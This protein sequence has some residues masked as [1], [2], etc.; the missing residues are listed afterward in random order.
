LVLYPQTLNKKCPTCETHPL[1]NFWTQ[2]D[3]KTWLESPKAC[4]GN[5][6]KYAFLKDE[7]GK[8]LPSETVKV[9]HKAV[10]AGWT[11]LVNCSIAL[12]TWGKASASACQTFHTILEHEFLIFKLAENGWKLEYLCT[13]TYSAWCKHHLNEN[14]QWKMAV[15][16]EDDSDEDS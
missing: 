1:V 7:N 11:E 9:I 4:L 6:G 5:Q 10:H 13:K 8:A 2:K 14:G 15:K 12:K 3:Y 16:E